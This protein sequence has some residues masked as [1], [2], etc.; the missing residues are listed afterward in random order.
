MCSLLLFLRSIALNVSNLSLGHLADHWPESYKSYIY[1][2]KQLCF[3]IIFFLNISLYFL[4]PSSLPFSLTT[5]EMFILNHFSICIGVLYRISSF[6]ISFNRN[7]VDWRKGF[8]GVIVLAIIR[9]IE[10]DIVDKL[11]SKDYI[12]QNEL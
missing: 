6:L 3:M 7:L 8:S 1:Q 12:F 9:N 4:S 2:I 5:F 10:L 11:H